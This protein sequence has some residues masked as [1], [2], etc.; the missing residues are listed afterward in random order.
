MTQLA[1]E[2][3]GWHTVGWAV[4]S[5]SVCDWTLGEGDGEKDGKTQSYLS[6][7]FLP[8]SNPRSKSKILPDQQESTDEISILLG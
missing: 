5:P 8:Q 2:L 7:P 1:T 4:G 3:A 6:I